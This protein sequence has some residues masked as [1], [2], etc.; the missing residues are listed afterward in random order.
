MSYIQM[1]QVPLTFGSDVADQHRN[2]SAAMYAEK[3]L[4]I[5]TNQY[6]KHYI[7]ALICSLF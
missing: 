4:M 6:I 2:I 5:K 3:F 1:V 7:L